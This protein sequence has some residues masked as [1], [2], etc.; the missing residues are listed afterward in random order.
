M[1]ERGKLI[2]L[3]GV[4]GAGKSTHM[5]FIADALRTR[6][7]HLIATREPGGTD[8]AEQIRTAILEQAMAPGM[9][10]LFLFAARADHVSRVIE[11]A[12]A[13]GTWVVC[14]RFTDATLAYQGAG[15]GVSAKSIEAMAALAHPGLA[16]ARTLLFDCPYEVSQRR[17]AAS[18]KT[19]DRFEREDRAFFE[20]VRAAYLERARA[21]PERIRLIDATGEMAEIRKAI[22]DSLRGL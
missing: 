4:D 8:L 12:L 13:A 22:A 17:L 11:P 1:S 18:R 10:T 2:T 9:E 21:E 14:D 5:E 19:L 7:P 15:K 3:E 16:P 20:R 6:A